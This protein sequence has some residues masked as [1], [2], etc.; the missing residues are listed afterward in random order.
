MRVCEHVE[1]LALA[2]Q[3]HLLIVN[4]EVSSDQASVNLLMPSEA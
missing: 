1:L 4:I 3:H 2:N